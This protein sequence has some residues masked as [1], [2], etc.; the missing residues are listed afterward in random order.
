LETAVLRQQLAILKRGYRLPK[1]RYRDR[2]FRIIMMRNWKDWRSTLQPDTVV[3]WIRADD[4]QQ[5]ELVRQILRSAAIN[6]GMPLTVQ[7]CGLPL[8]TL[9]L[10]PRG[11]AG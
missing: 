1:L 2:L 5:V 10:P 9:A 6:L 3:G 8:A 7:G 11:L 4:T